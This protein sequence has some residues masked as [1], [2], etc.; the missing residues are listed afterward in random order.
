MTTEDYVTI[1]YLRP[2]LHMLNS[3]WAHRDGELCKFIRNSI[4]DYLSGA[5]QSHPRVIMTSLLEPEFR[6]GYQLL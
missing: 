6:T 4:F 5:C 2:V 1:Y 3:L